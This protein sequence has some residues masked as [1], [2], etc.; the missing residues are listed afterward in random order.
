MVGRRSG[1]AEHVARQAVA[2]QMAAEATEPGE[3]GRARLR[4]NDRGA[5]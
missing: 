5:Q 2:Q 1:L 3:V 4:Q